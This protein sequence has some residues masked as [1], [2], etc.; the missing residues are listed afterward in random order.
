M[1]ALE[2]PSILIDWNSPYNAYRDKNN[3]F[4]HYSSLPIFNLN[5]T[6]SI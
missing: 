3:H 5:L 2:N 6:S 4:I 1:I